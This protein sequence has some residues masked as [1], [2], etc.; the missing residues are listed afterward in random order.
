MKRSIF[1]ISAALILAAV[2]LSS[3]Q[4]HLI[5]EKLFAW[6]EQHGAEQLKQRL[7]RVRQ[8]YHDSP[9]PLYL[10][11][12]LEIDAREAADIYQKIA[13]KFPKSRYA[14]AAMM[15]L[16]EYFFITKSYQRARYWFD[17]IADQFPDSDFLAL[18][19]FYSGIC[20]KVLGDDKLAKRSLEKFLKKF[21]NHQFADFARKAIA[22]PANQQVTATPAGSIEDALKGTKVEAPQN[23]EVYSVQIGAFSKRKNAIRL[24]EKYDFLGE[25]IEIVPSSAG[26]KILY[27]VHI[28]KFSRRAEAENFAN[29]LKKAY[30]LTFRIVKK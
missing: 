3:A 23:L 16:G 13:A 12:Y 30:G 21:P 5:D 24:R 17:K 6:I 1:C 9:I 2:N 29:H 8:Q 15:K 25:P 18:A 10:E 11:G 4:T 20:S 14:E 26:D 19:Y 7:N 27:L 28:G 22:R